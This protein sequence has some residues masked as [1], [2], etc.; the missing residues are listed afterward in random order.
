MK[1]LEFLNLQHLTQQ[2]E[3]SVLLNSAFAEEDF[4]FSGKRFRIASFPRRFE[5]S[6]QL[7]LYHSFRA[8]GISDN[9]IREHM[10]EVYAGSEWRIFR[11]WLDGKI[12]AD[13]TFR[14]ARGKVGKLKHVGLI[15]ER[16]MQF[17]QKKTLAQ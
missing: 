16:R 13:L 3:Q 6:F 14:D 15:A 11:L 9:L 1:L 17:V 12:A 2:H 8:T 7:A 4:A 10:V 5:S